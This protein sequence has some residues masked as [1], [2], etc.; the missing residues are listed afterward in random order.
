MNISS[1][2]HPNFLIGGA[3]ASGTSFLVDLLTQH[4]LI[5]LP[6]EMRPEP[7]FFYKDWEYEKGITYYCERWFSDVPK[8]CVAVGEKSTSYLFGGEGV[9]KRIKQFYPDMKFVFLLRNPIER[10]WAS[11][12]YTVLQG[13]EPYSFREALD[14]EQERVQKEKGYWAQIQPH[15]YTGRS[16]YGAQIKEFLDFFSIKNMLFLKSEYFFKNSEE[17][18]YDICDF[19]GIRRHRCIVS[20]VS[21]HSN[22]GVVDAALQVELR[23]YF[24]ERFDF[25]IEKIRMDEDIFLF[26]DSKSDK[27]K[28]NQLKNNVTECEPNIPEDCR[29]YLKGIFKEDRFLLS[30]YVNFDLADWV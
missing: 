6:K 12:R 24:A 17:S 13:L 4:P 22:Y 26:A 2:R 29:D 3:A 27:V 10:T 7:H 23:D 20:G 21:H 14:R 8:E 15:N 5:F 18:I 28:I 30:K 16:M 11:Y 1:F 19:L 9:A 25:L